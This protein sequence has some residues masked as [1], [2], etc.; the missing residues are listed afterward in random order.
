[1][2]RGELA[3]ILVSPSPLRPED[4]AVVRERAVSGGLRLL[5]VPGEPP[6][7]PWLAAVA[8]AADDA[9]LEALSAEAGVDLTATTDDRPFFFL[10]VPLSAWLSPRRSRNC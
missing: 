3:N 4:V 7:S 8:E 6:A 5:L 9:R 2:A 1:M 10:Q